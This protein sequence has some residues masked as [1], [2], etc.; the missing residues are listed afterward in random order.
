M[1]AAIISFLQGLILPLLES[2][3]SKAQIS[4]QVSTLQKQQQN[5]IKA[6][7]KLQGSKTPDEI[8]QAIKAIALSD[9]N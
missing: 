4:Q 8:A 6:I 1:I 3:I 5:V 2:L 7:A 9:N